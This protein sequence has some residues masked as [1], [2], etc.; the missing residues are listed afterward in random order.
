MRKL[1]AKWVLKRLNADQKRQR[2]QS[3][4]Q[5]VECFRCD[6]ND[7]VS[8]LLTM[9]ETWLYHYDP[10]TKQQSM[11]WRHS[12]SPRPA[13]K[14]SECKNPLGKFSPRFFGIKKASS[15]LIIFQ[16]AKLST[17]SIT[18]LCWCNWRTFEGKTPREV[19]QGGLVLT[20]QCRGS[21]DTCN[22]EETGLPGF[23]VS[24]SST[25]F[26]GSGLVGLPP[27][28]WTEKTI[29][30]SP[31]FVR[32]GGH[33]RRGDLVGRTNFWI[34]FLVACKSYSNGLRSG[35][36]FVGSM[37]NKSRVYTL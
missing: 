14:I 30:R 37:L 34:F 18:H 13:P 11:E 1:S 21:P 12:G 8:W 19:H 7:F 22:P 9:D 28:P 31:F 35:L 15:S 2:C 27:V 4:E 17:R 25:L 36:S 3:S 32:R 29:E 26:S 6:P 5:R 20:R 10:E 23:P 16:R 24:W 33:C